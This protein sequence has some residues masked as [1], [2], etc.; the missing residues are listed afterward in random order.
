MHSLRYMLAGTPSH[1]Q[2]Q[3]LSMRPLQKSLFIYLLK[4]RMLKSIHR[5]SAEIKRSLS[6]YEHEA[7]DI[8]ESRSIS[9]PRRILIADR[10]EVQ[11]RLSELGNEKF[12]VK[13]QVLTGGRGKG[14]FESGLKG[15]VK[16]VEEFNF[17]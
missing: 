17:Y 8:L 16:V 9:T 1:I 11:S 15:G 13:A 5:V 12:V 2:N 4:P 6:L 14:T 10:D 7:F 3:S